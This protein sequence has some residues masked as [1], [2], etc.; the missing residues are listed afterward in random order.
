MK[1]KQS[2]PLPLELVKDFEKTH[3]GCWEWIDYVREGKGKDLPDWN[4]LCFCPLGGAQ[5]IMIEKYHDTDLN[6]AAL[7]AALASWRQYKEIYSFSEELKE[8]LY[9][10][11][12]DIVMPIDI[13]YQIPFP[14]VYISTGNDEGFFTFFEHDMNTFHME[15]RFCIIKKT[16][17]GIIKILNTWVHLKD[18]YTILDGINDG[19]DLAIKNAEKYGDKITEVFSAMDLDLF[20][21]D[22]AKWFF[23]EIAKRFQLV[24]Y[25]C[26]ENAEIEENAQQKKITRKPSG[27]KPKDT[28]R[29]IRSWDVG[30][31]Y[32]Y[33]VRKTQTETTSAAGES[34]AIKTHGTHNSHRPHTRRGHWHHYWIGSRSDGSRK[35]IL[36]WTAPIFVGGSSDDAI[37]TIHKI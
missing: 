34:N 5:G 6:T 31:K 16:I 27:N 11:S 19:L 22:I 2:L 30:V 24:L 7:L 20:S 21:E 8:T 17:D 25:I 3:P 13:L 10:Q 14:C 33:A 4:N 15:L 1:R 23:D 12:D 36:K 29:E 37:T 32:A 26:A 35:L 18:G 28:Y 9:A